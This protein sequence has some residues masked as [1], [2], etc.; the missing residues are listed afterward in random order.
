M[1]VV[2]WVTEEIEKKHG[3][4]TVIGR[5]NCIYISAGFKDHVSN[6][7]FSNRVDYTLGP[8]SQSGPNLNNLFLHVWLVHF[9]GPI[10]VCFSHPS[11]K[12]SSQV[13]LKRFS[14]YWGRGKMWIFRTLRSVAHY[15]QLPSGEMPV[16]QKHWYLMV[17]GL[18][19]KMQSGSLLYIG[20]AVVGVRWVSQCLSPSSFLE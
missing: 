7:V 3:N 18:T 8:R 11:S 1:Q 5:G 9:G 13:I 14:C 20:H 16:L 12:Q 6:K 19:P 4:P 2:Q 15:M 17:Q 10:C